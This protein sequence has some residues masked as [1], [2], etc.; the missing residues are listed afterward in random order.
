MNQIRYFLA[1]CQ[2]QHFTRAAKRCGISQPSLSTSIKRLEQEFGGPLFNRGITKTSL[3]DL[4]CAVRPHLEKLYQC[5]QDA[6]REAAQF[7]FHP[8]NQAAKENGGFYAKATATRRRSHVRKTIVC[9]SNTFGA[10]TDSI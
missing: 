9:D 6:R 10:G 1:V 4:G 8:S 7:K 3:S 2:E 5:A